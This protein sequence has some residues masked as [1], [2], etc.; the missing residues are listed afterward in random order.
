MMEAAGP[1]PQPVTMSLTEAMDVLDEFHIK[2][3]DYDRVMAAMEI[4]FNGKPEPEPPG[5]SEADDTS[6]MQTAANEM[7]STSRDRKAMR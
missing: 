3:S 4:V 1:V 7:F 5:E 2:R 6:E